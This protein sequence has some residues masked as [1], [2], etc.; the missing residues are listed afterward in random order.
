MSKFA[1][2]KIGPKQYIVNEGAE[3][4][5]PKFVAEEGKKFKEAE[6]LAAGDEKDMKIG[7]P[8]V[9]KAVVEL[10]IIGQEKGE[11][12]TTKVYKAKTRYRRTKGHRKDVT[13]FK[14]TKITY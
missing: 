14:V 7:A 6:V 13:R 1:V 3:Y 8:T 11:K 4:T 5:V 12:V 9:E 10:D 2:I